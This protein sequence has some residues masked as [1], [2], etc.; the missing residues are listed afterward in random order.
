[1]IDIGGP[2][3]FIMFGFNKKK[4]TDDK[5]AKADS[6][7][8]DQK[9][10]EIIV[11]NIEDGVILFDN[12]GTIQLLSP[13][14][15]KLT[16]WSAQDSTGINIKQ[17]ITLV[18]SKG[19]VYQEADNPLT[20]ILKSNNPIRDNGAYLM[21]KSKS[22]IAI[23]LSLSPILNE[24]GATSG[25]VA[26]LRDVTKE[27]A[28]DQ[29][30]QDFVSTASHEMRTPVAE[31][32]GYLALALNEKVAT[33]DDRAKG[34]I[35]KAYASTRHLGKLFQD[36]LTTTKAEDGKLVSNPSVLEMGSFL[37]KLTEGLKMLS[38]QKNLLT[39]FV[40]GSSSLINAR[41]EAGQMVKPLYYIYADP[42]RIE[43]VVNNLYD[44]AVKYTE[45]GKITI[46]LTGND[47][48]VQ[49]YIKD[50]GAGIPPEDVEHLFQKFYRVDSTATRTIGGSGLGLF[51]CKKIV[52]LYNGRIWAESEVGK[53]ST[54][55]INLPRLSTQKAT[56]L[57]SPNTVK[58][59]VKTT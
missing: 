17:V 23:S 18:N 36:L 29:Q 47:K 21:S 11:Q 42:E 22:Q 26:V 1:M 44:N 59:S 16:G 13:S 39:D 58:P 8:M 56:E 40:I 54:F 28:Q 57:N 35:D 6:L 33:I 46:G 5:S 12:Q 15:E 24:A 50:T 14:A 55:F 7:A 52:E 30:K 19:E 53:G 43:Q 34:F 4:N 37:E 27:R 2:R 31:I 25:A 10:F 49:F 51:I 20:K 3:L 9:R 38:K 32:E 45:K 48:V 41:N